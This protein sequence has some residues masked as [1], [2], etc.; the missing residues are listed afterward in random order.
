MRGC[1]SRG[2]DERTACDSFTILLDRSDASP[3]E[4]TA[5]H[6]ED[7]GYG[8][9]IDDI[10]RLLA[11]QPPAKKDRK[12][13]RAD[14]SVVFAPLFARPSSNEGLKVDLTRRCVNRL[15]L[16]EALRQQLPA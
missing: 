1:L 12:I 16:L 5:T 8:E 4:E 6:R 3:D 10:D 9:L 7:G 2:V 15:T 14:F 13:G 11:R